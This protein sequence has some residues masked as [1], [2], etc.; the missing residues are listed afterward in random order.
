MRVNDSK[1]KLMCISAANSFEV[2]A[3]LK[4]RHGSP[5]ESVDSFKVLGV[6]LQCNGKFD[7]HV[8]NIA[9]KMRSRTWALRVLR[10]KGMTERDLV[11]VYKS[12]IRPLVEYAIPAWHSSIT[13]VQADKLEAQQTLA[14]KNI[15]GVGM[16]ARRL[17]NK[18]GLPLL[19]KRRTEI[20]LKFAQK[21]LTSDRFSHWFEPRP[22]E[23]RPRRN[24]VNYN[25]F[26]EDKSRTERMKNSPKNYC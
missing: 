9:K 4:D 23:D 10:K 21:C 26:T 20:C 6:T 15:F 17:R 1:T 3:R 16:S 19:E 12:M 7:Q 5:I 2:K 22:R 11:T 8:N 18:A 25:L 13:Q 14:L 24:S